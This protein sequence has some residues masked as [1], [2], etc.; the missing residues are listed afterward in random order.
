MSAGQVSKCGVAIGLTG[1]SIVS[2]EG[3]SL[4][5]RRMRRACMYAVVATTSA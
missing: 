5:V 2:D 4:A 1:S 3:M